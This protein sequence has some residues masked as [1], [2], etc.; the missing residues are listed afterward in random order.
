MKSFLD[1]QLEVLTKNADA[2]KWID[3]FVNSN[4]PKFAGKSKEK[5]KQ[6]A[7]AAYYANQRNEEAIHEARAT[8][9][10]K[11]SEGNIK[12]AGTDKDIAYKTH[13]SL[14][15]KELG[16]KLYKN[17]VS[18]LAEEVQQHELKRIHKEYLYHKSRPTA[19]VLKTHKSLHKVQ[20]QN[21][22]VAEM[23]GKEGLISDI[24]HDA[25]GKTRMAA[26]HSLSS[27][28]KKALSE[29]TLD[30]ISKEAVYVEE[31]RAESGELF[32]SLVDKAHAASERG[33]H[34]QAKRHLSNA[35]TA[36]YGITS[37]NI[38]K[39]KKSFDKYKELKHSYTNYDDHVREETDLEEAHKINDRVEIIKGSA[40]GTIGRIGEIRHGA[41][42][43]AAKTYTVYHG[44]HGATQV[45]KEHIRKLKEEVLNEISQETKVS[46]INKASKDI[47]DRRAKEKE[48]L[49]DNGTKRKNYPEFKNYIKKTDKR[50]KMVN[51]MSNEEVELDEATSKVASGEMFKHHLDKATEAS[52]NGAH[53]RAKY[54]LGIAKTARYGMNTKALMKH[55]EAL[56][57]YKELMHSYTNSDDHVREE[58]EP[59]DELSKD[60]LSSYVKAA[61]KD[62]EDAGR[63]QEHY[64]AQS[65]YDRGN[66]R[67][68]GISKAVDKL[69][70]EEVEPIEELSKST[71]KSYRDKA[72]KHMVDKKAELGMRMGTKADWKRIRGIENA[73]SKIG[74]KGTRNESKSHDVIK[75]KLDDIN[76]KPESKSPAQKRAEAEKQTKEKEMKEAVDTIKK[77]EKGDVISFSHEGDWEKSSTKN[78]GARGKGKA[79]HLSDVGLKTIKKLNTE[80]VE[81]LDEGLAP[82]YN[83]YKV[84]GKYIRDKK[85]SKPHES[86]EAHGEWIKGF[87]DARDSH[88]KAVVAASKNG[89]GKYH[90]HT[91]KVAKRGVYE[92]VEELD[93]LSKDTLSSYE[94]KARY[95]ALKHNL[96][97]DLRSQGADYY[98]A[99]QHKAMANKRTVGYKKAFAKL[100]KEDTMLTYS[101]FMAQLEEGKAD[102]LK[103]KLA[104]DRENRLNNYDYSKE[105]D[106][107]SNKTIVKGHSYGAGDEEEEGEDDVKTAK[108][109]AVKR[110]RGRP[111]GSKSGARV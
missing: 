69:T 72:I 61:S 15:T 37:A 100:N 25:H 39:H 22:S 92:E 26:Y 47:T 73:S 88:V 74:S 27:K 54:H 101:E 64:G 80:E 45:S 104:A 51:K 7:L 6:M 43:G 21:Y 60:T 102:D 31:S 20:S 56:G 19:D 13:K 1:L 57:S 8:Y 46:Y 44:E 58:V 41:F 33:D 65:D 66:K 28:H 29:E 77:N 75:A 11:D 9:T 110:G 71:L 10:I 70:K 48:A 76:R 86:D 107:K 105:K 32:K 42:K 40:K 103:D 67:Q 78:G 111:A 3:D 93:E 96:V 87:N 81:E 35:Q 52:K 109:E 98:G 79:S 62:A 53:S 97:A 84:D 50:E 14:N 16:H 83:H 34:T 30:E 90:G 106:K 63:D 68:K 38:P 36:R 23:G 99:G 85:T 18:C 24:M 2:G 108:P 89:P 59:I 91:V 49:S 5:R 94:T 17:G 4:D 12:H 95:A 55:K 82:G